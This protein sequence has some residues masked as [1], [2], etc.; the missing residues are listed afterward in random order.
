MPLRLFMSSHIDGTQI[1]L[2][3]AGKVIKL[4]PQLY[5]TGGRPGSATASPTG[6]KYLW[7][8]IFPLPPPVA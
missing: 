6:S 5:A 8:L 4:P 3:A 2:D 1:L 7:V